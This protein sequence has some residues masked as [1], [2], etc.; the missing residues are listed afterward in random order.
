MVQNSFWIRSTDGNLF[1]AAGDSGSLILSQAEGE[2]AGTF[3]VV[4][5]LYG[6]GTFTGGV[7]GTVANDINSVFGALDLSTVCTCIARALIRAIFGLERVENSVNERLVSAKIRQLHSFRRRTLGEARFG[8]LANDV[9]TREAARVGEILTSDDEAFGL[10]TR[11]L[12]RWVLMPTNFDIVDAEF[13]D[14]TVDDLI[15]FA[16]ESRGRTEL[17]H[18][19]SWPPRCCWSPSEVRRL[20]P[21]CDRRSWTSSP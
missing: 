15:R 4:G 2:V 7:P 18:L 19:S 5:L 13:D 1:S 12:R 20:V 3:P 6:G 14:E 8:K 11:A 21:F 17:W 16:N 10:L 9:I